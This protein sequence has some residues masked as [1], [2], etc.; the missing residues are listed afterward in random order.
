MNLRSEKTQLIICYLINILAVFIV[1]FSFLY[2]GR[3]CT[4]WGDNFYTLLTGNYDYNIFDLLKYK[5]HGGGYF[6]YF[7]AKLLSFDMP[8]YFHMHPYD[9]ISNVE[10]GFRGIFS[11]LTLIIMSEFIFLYKKTNYIKYICIIVLSLYFCNTFIFENNCIIMENYRYYRYFFVQLFFS[12][13]WLYVFRNILRRQKTNVYKLIF[14]CFC[15]Y[16]IGAG[17]EIV[18]L[19]TAVL[20]LL[21]I[22]YNVL[23]S[24]FN[25][26]KPEINLFE[27][28][29]NL[30]INFYLPVFIFYVSFFFTITS[31]GF[32]DTMIE[33]RGVGHFSFQTDTLKEFL[34]LYISNCFQNHIIYWVIFIIVIIASIIILKKENNYKEFFITY[35]VQFSILLVMF[36][37]ILGGKN[38]ENINDYF[39][40]H[41]FIN[42]LYKFMILYPLLLG[43]GYIINNC[44]IKKKIIVPCIIMI[45]ILFSIQ[46]TYFIYKNNIE[47]KYI[48]YDVM[49]VKKK[50]YIAHKLVRFYTL[51][52]KNPF[53][54]TNMTFYMELSPED[55]MI[56][57]NIEILSYSMYLI[58]QDENILKLKLKITDD[59]LE[60]FYNDGGSLTE[61][62]LK[63]IKFS[64]L[65][66]DKFV[67]N[68]K[69]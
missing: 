11:A 45:S 48:N 68:K 61:E 29:Y 35:F 23:I 25:R 21:P 27:Y 28:K 55:K 1:T 38:V 53:Y 54:P 18:Y 44:N 58:Y 51:K 56:S 17:V 50:Y 36:S 67:L 8:L 63:N 6:G 41:H 3:N 10:P 37:L 24:L 20:I 39:I 7:I 52:N 65:F 34:S 62:E 47:K 49:E 4:F 42:L 43:I 30:D 16:V 59:T 14:I 15:G 5:A 57:E 26:M 32:K 19:V 12:I 9:F 69:N 13:F 64:R 31:S 60:K 33:N 46:Q 22:V 2:V 66:E 40:N